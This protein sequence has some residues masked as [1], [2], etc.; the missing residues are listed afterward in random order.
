MNVRH[1]LVLAGLHATCFA[2]PSHAFKVYIFCDM[3]GCSGVTGSVQIFGA[4][5][6]EGKRAMEGDI[7][8]CIT[9][10]V[11]AGATEIVVRDGHAGGTNVD[12]AA[13]DQRAKL[14]Q[15]PTPGVRFKDLD[16]AAALILLGYHAMALTPN[17]V[18]AHSY[19]SATIQRMRLNGREVGEIGVDAS[20]AAEHGVPVVLVTGDDKVTAETKAWVPGAA[21]AQVKRGTGWQ[22]ADIVP[23]DE[24]R[25]LIRKATEEAVRR[26]ADIRPVA[27]KHPATLEWDYLPEGSLRTHNPDFK[28]V[29]DP[30]RVKKTA[31]T[32]EFLLVGK[33]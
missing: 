19:S 25:A 6:D 27:T 26:R 13:I 3:E 2:G 33:R 24:A 21:T 12:P 23:V 17:G 7:N 4:R 30:R 14:V 9:G 18:L 8:A 16:G 20:I 29:A 10:C 31:D 5:A 11:A 28:P 32:V 1:A 15:G 22:S